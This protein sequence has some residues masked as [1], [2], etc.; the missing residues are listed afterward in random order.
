MGYRNEFLTATRGLGILTSVFEEF[1]PWKGTI[2]GRTHGVLFQYGSEKP[3]DMPAL[4]SRPG[5]IFIA[6]GD[7][8][9][10]GMVV[11]EN[12]REND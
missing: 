4:T 3:V 7:E 2:P 5:V 9:Y 11:G 8:V 12:S 10:E 1:A 6:P